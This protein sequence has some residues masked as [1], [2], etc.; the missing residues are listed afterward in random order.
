M[1]NLFFSN[2]MKILAKKKNVLNISKFSLSGGTYVEQTSTSHLIGDCT[3][4]G[5][6]QNYSVFQHINKT[7]TYFDIYY[8]GPMVTLK[9]REMFSL[10]VTNVGPGG[11]CVTSFHLFQYHRLLLLPLFPFMWF[12]K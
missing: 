3:A 12:C 1:E 9:V 8:W 6:L 11:E 7:I 2:E 4:L 5:S 10:K